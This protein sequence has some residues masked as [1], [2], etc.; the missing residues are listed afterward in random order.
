MM[1]LHRDEPAFTRIEVTGR[2]EHSDYERVLPELEALVAHGN[3]RVLLELHDFKGFTPAA[4]VDELKFDF[5][6]RKDFERV[7]VVSDS[8]L[9]EI[10]IRMVRPFF[11]GRVKIFDT[12]ERGAAE[13]WIRQN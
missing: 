11:T 12:S 1:T 5:R 2:L 4:L 9:Q 7:A 10:G 13:A 6:H 8:A 3:A